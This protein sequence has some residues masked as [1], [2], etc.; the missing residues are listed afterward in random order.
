MTPTFV[1]IYRWR[2]KDGAEAAFRTA[3]HRMTE[4]IHAV[5][6]SFGSRLHIEPDGTYCAIAL[7]P[8]REAWQATQPPLDDKEDQ[9]TLQEAIVERLPTLTMELVDDLWS[10]P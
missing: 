10:I 3:W 2:I 4:R 9:R 7:W 6:K 5:R 8:S 1:V